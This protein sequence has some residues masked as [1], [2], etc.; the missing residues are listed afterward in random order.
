MKRYYVL[1]I[2]LLFV[3]N[4]CKKEDTV[5]EKQP[6]KKENVTTEK[7]IV[8]SLFTISKNEY[9]LLYEYKNGDAYQII[10]INILDHKRIKFHLIT[11]TLPC[12]TEYHGIAINNYWDQDPEMDSFNGE[13]YFVDEYFMEKKEYQLAIRLADDLSKVIIKYHVK[14][15]TETDCLPI[16]HEIM[17]RIK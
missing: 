8:D 12:D 6:I 3:I 4:S 1:L 16:D 2:L 17:R 5:K 11:E 13:G 10:G 15:S 9:T 7:E 14:D